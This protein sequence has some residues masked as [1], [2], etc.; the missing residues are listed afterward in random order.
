MLDELYDKVCWAS[1]HDTVKVV[2][3]TSKLPLGFS[4]GL[5][6]G[7]FM[8]DRQTVF[9]E[10]VYN[11]VY[12]SFQVARA[13][14]QSAKIFIAALSGSVIGSAASIAFSCDFRIAAP[15]TWFWLPDV[16]YGGFLADGGIELLSKLVGNS[17]AYMLGL[18]NDRINLDEADKWG[19]I[20]KIA[21]I[22]KLEETAFSF[23]KRLCGFSFNTLSLHKKIINDDLLNDYREEQLKSILTSE[24]TYLK[25]KSYM[26]SKKKS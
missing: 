2:V 26:Q 13:I 14:T 25:L 10:K 22:S 8:D 23:A 19:L 1:E 21:D 5:D 24:D 4:S 17:R 7:S 20:Y 15:G 11:A 12:K 18:T 9:V 3:L 16:Q 6:L